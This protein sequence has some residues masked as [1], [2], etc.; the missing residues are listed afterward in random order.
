MNKIS[1]FLFYIFAWFIAILPVRLQYLFSDGVFVIAYYLIGYRRNVVMQNLKNAFPEK[2]ETELHII[3]K[4]YY[5]HLV[6]VFIEVLAMFSLNEKR[7][8]KRHKFINIEL[9]Q[10]LYD[11]NVGIVGVSG[12]YNNWEWLN[13]LNSKVNYIGLAIFKPIS[14]PLYENFMNKIREK[15]GSLAVSMNNTLREIIEQKRKGKLPFVLMVSD[16]APSYTEKNYWTQFLNQETLFFTGVEKI[17]KK[18]NF[19]VVFIK[20]RKIKRGYY[21]TTFELITEEPLKTEE[22]F[23]TKQYVEKLEELIKENPN[24]W[25]WSHKRWK[26]KRQI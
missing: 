2:T 14:N 12:H 11:K 26:N 1:F 16:Q 8:Q 13:F 7:M 20:M 24:Y 9:L 6:D 4:K 22:Y 23:I 3:E 17:A 19:A 5:Q 15:F 18:Y 25:L 10:N 21:E